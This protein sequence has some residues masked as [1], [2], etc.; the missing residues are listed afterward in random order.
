MLY[1]IT[2]LQRLNETKN[3]F[4]DRK[5]EDAMVETMALN[6]GTTKRAIRNLFNTVKKQR[7]K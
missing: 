5:C 7:T 1:S 6:W 2:F 4:D 3:R